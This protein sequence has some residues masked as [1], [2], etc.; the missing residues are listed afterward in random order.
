MS[1]PDAPSCTCPPSGHLPSCWQ[2]QAA[3]DARRLA[4]QPPAAVLV[5]IRD[6][7]PVYVEPEA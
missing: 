2:T 6:G 7:H 1:E 4:E 3:A 5:A